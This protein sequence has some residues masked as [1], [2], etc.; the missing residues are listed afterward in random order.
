MWGY[1]GY[2]KSLHGCGVILGMLR[3]SQDVGLSCVCKD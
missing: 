1:H 2:L 3:G